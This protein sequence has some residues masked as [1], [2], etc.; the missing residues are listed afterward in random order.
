MEANEGEKKPL[1]KKA[2]I[3]AAAVA[4]CAAIYLMMPGRTRKESAEA[5]SK[6]PEAEQNARQTAN[7][8][9]NMIETDED[10]TLTLQQ[11]AGQA[12]QP[13]APSQPAETPVIVGDTL[14]YEGAIYVKVGYVKRTVPDTVEIG[15][16]KYVEII[17][18]AEP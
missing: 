9:E 5:T 16:K 13:A 4:T 15:G 3:A 17:P 6:T 2:V 12:A 8:F 18:H 10:G 11:T 14:T 7:P 1:N